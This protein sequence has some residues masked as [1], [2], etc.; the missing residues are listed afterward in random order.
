MGEVTGL[1]EAAQNGDATAVAAVFDLTYRELLD[2]AR[3]RL[4][5]RGRITVL[6]TTGLVHECYLRL[7]KV[8]RLEARDR[9][10]FLC[11]AA[12]AMRSIA[13]DYARRRL[14]QRRGG[15]EVRVPLD[16]D[17]LDSASGDAEQVLNVDEALGELTQLD[18]RLAQVVELKY[19]AGLS[20]QEIAELREVDERTVR[21]DW[22]KARMLLFNALKA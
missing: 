22:E 9:A 6:D 3:A 15:S 16:T 5:Q 13:V 20:A 18:P 2:L 7:T 14:A 10:H 1:L 4:R 12:R 8:G 19:F 17:V 21:R 11:Y